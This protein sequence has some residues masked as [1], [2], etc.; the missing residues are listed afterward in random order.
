M[1]NVLPIPKLLRKGKAEQ[2]LVF[3]SVWKYLVYFKWLYKYWK[4][5]GEARIQTVTLFLYRKSLRYFQWLFLLVLLSA[6]GSVEICRK[7]CLAVSITGQLAF[8]RLEL[9]RADSPRTSSFSSW[10]SKGTVAPFPDISFSDLIYIHSD[11]LFQEKDET[12]N[13][14]CN[15]KTLQK[16]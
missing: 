11:S 9:E 12:K 3:C 5:N 8:H 14:G 13:L 15:Y 6:K 2:L 4:M 1:A 10:H 7:W 16:L